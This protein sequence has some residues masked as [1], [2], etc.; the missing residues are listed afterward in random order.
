LTRGAI[1]SPLYVPNRTKEKDEAARKQNNECK[2]IVCHF[3][4]GLVDFKNKGR[5]VIWLVT[6]TRCW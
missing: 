2:S 5:R 3:T 6:Q 1:A 4:I